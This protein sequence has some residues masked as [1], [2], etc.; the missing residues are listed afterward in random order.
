MPG[1]TGGKGSKKI[2]RGKKK[3][4]AKGNPISQYIRNKITAQQYWS[5]IGM[6]GKY[7]QTL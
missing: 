5:M 1:K 7:I 6:S 3:S 2:G 4:A